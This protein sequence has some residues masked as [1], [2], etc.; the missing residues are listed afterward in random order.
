MH[1]PAETFRFSVVGPT[2]PAEVLAGSAGPTKRVL[3]P[4]L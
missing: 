2:V 4:F 1:E 3:L